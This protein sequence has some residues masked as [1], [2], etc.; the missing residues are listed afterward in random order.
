MSKPTKST[1]QTGSAK[2]DLSGASLWDF[3]VSLYERDPVREI[4][5][6]L[7]ESAGADVNMIL[8]CLWLGAT[9][10]GQIDGDTFA[11]LSE[12]VSVWH[13]DVVMPL[14]AA[15]VRLRKPPKS[16]APSAATALRNQ[17]KDIE[18]A[19]ERIE[20]EVLAESLERS[21]VA[22]DRERRSRDMENSLTAYLAFIGAPASEDVAD[23][24]AILV[25][26]GSA[27]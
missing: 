2:T 5:L 13:K 25:K 27:T 26:E 3:A 8:Y 14:R 17:I 6:A 23:A 16:V 15:R 20:L 4:C 10:R 7:Q 12:A 21:P 19:A 1:D 18:L 11:H 9:G 22:H 24:I